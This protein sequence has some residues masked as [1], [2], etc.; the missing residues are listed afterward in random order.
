MAYWMPMTLWS[1]ENTY[2]A[3]EAQHLV[4]VMDFVRRRAASARRQ[5]LARSCGWSPGGYFAPGVANLKFWGLDS[6][7]ATVTDAVCVPSFSCH[8]VIS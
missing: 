8:A 7:A 2:C 5:L 3:P 4:V 6:L 1:T